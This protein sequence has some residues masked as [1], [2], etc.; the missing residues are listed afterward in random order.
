MLSAG[1]EQSVLQNDSDV[2]NA[3]V[4]AGFSKNEIDELVGDENNAEALLQ[5]MEPIRVK[6]L[7]AF[8]HRAISALAEAEAKERPNRKLRV[9]LQEQTVMASGRHGALKSHDDDGDT[10][11]VL[12]KH[13][14]EA[15]RLLLRQNAAGSEE[16]RSALLMLWHE[17]G[18]GK[19]TTGIACIAA[20]SNI[21]PHPS[22][23][24]KALIVSPISV[25]S[26]HYSEAT[27]W[28]NMSESSILL[29][30]NKDDLTAEAI[31]QAEVIVVTYSALTAA[32]ATFVWRNP[33]A[34]Q[35][36]SRKTGQV[37]WF[38]DFELLSRPRQCDLNKNP[39]W[40]SDRP[41]PVHPI[42]AVPKW[43]ICIVDEAQRVSNP[44]T[45]NSKAVR[46]ICTRSVHR[47]FG[48]GTPVR[49]SVRQMA[50]LFTSADSNPDKFQ[51]LAQWVPQNLSGKGIRRGTL[52]EAHALFVHRMTLPSLLPEY[53]RIRVEFSPFVG[54]CADG[55]I[56]LQ[57]ITH[58][59]SKVD[60]ARKMAQSAMQDPGMRQAI[61]GKL[62][63]CVCKTEQYCFDL[64][65]GRMGPPTNTSWNLKRDMVESRKNPS[66]QLK[67]LYRLI[68]SR[69][70]AGKKRI[71][72]YSEQTSYLHILADF[73][74]RLGDVGKMLKV[75]GGVSGTRRDKIV[76]EFLKT[77]LAVLFISS[78]GSE[79]VNLAPGCET[80]ISFGAFPWSPQELKQAEARVIR[81]T[82]NKPVELLE[83]V[84]HG[85]SGKL[86]NL[87]ADKER[88]FSGLIDND[89]KTFKEADAEKA[90]W[91]E[92]VT[93]AAGL[94]YIGPD[95]NLAAT[96]TGEQAA[97]P[98]LAFD[99]ELPPVSF[100]EPD[101]A[102][103]ELDC[104]PSSEED[105]P[106]PPKS[107]VVTGGGSSSREPNTSEAAAQMAELMAQM[108][109]VDSD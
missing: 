104:Y 57:A 10:P 29:A 48:S 20:V 34:R 60:T 6:L 97:T 42:F 102:D 78:A 27:R 59:N 13:Q 31:E 108:E 46:R 93:I 82:Q 25:A 12:Y 23:G 101:E 109:D 9:W 37:R 51:V 69:Q 5:S 92:R 76:K 45:W 84:P 4:T 14:C 64:H 35:T 33:R 75:V 2:R 86:D 67:L 3:L 65:L 40:S 106:P 44:Q 71:L 15:V 66:E 80:V 54:R 96:N 7:M 94:N 38:A 56:D 98:K 99:M 68:K 55:S 24:V 63:S 36:V 21:I 49:G 91:R 61:M 47:V 77:R 43:D 52:E 72:V 105:E 74:E 53:R 39:A 100:P 19:T 79:G 103:S 30:R 89:F 32:L 58:Y 73:C 41:P 85:A 83:V 88:L 28:L 107:S 81:M 50:G 90:V 22:R 87:H 8:P 70:Q 62:I 17:M 11:L 95:G 1:T 26:F 16:P 18:L